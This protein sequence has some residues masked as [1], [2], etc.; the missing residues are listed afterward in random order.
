MRR[1]CREG[2]RGDEK[3]LLGCERI[4]V[5]EDFQSKLTG[6]K[7]V[8]VQL[9]GYLEATCPQIVP[10]RLFRVRIP[11]VLPQH[12]QLGLSPCHVAQWGSRIGQKEL[13]SRLKFQEVPIFFL[14]VS[15]GSENLIVL[16]FRTFRRFA[17]PLE[18]ELSSSEG[19]FSLLFRDLRRIYKRQSYHVI[20]LEKLKHRTYSIFLFTVGLE[21]TQK[22]PRHQCSRRKFT[23]CC[24]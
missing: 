12:V 9:Q 18:L 15:P 7:P 8:P 24:C 3:G 19:D 13:P 4:Q 2:N 10:P 20:F 16:G 11:A 6:E 23:P 22:T 5:R 17:S 14:L 1:D 21:Q